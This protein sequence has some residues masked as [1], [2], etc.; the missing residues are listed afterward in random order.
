MMPRLELE[1]VQPRLTAVA[2]APLIQVV[3]VATVG[4]VTGA[5]IAADPGIAIGLAGLGVLWAVPR[6]FLLPLAILCSRAV[7][8]HLGVV[9]IE[10]FTVTDVVLVVWILRKAPF[11]VSVGRLRLPN[12][13]WWLLGFLAWAWISLYVNDASANALL[14]LTVYIG[15]SV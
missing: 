13:N 10:P 12:A 7:G 5:V 9:D 1:R 14:R 15:V 2:R 3:G 11:L 8:G 6:R 4:I